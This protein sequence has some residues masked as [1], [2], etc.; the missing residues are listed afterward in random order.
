MYVHVMGT[1]IDDRCKD[2]TAPGK[3]TDSNL[4]KSV[5]RT[6]LIMRF[7]FNMLVVGDIVKPF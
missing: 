5:T 4:G 7:S 6:L 3:K 2:E 1:L